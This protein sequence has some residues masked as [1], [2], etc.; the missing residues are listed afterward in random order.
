MSHS[1]TTQLLTGIRVL[2]L[3][4]NLPGPFATRLL[5][6]LGAHIVKIE[7]PGGDEARALPPLFERLNRGKECVRLDLKQ[8]GER[9]RL[10]QMVAG[11]DVLVEGFRPGVMD[12]L[13]LGWE[14]LRQ[15]NPKLV[16]CSITGYGQRGPW[17]DRAGH[18]LNYMAMSGVLDVLRGRDGAPVLGNV[19]WGDVASGSMFGVAQTLAALLHVQRGGQ[20]CHL[21]ISMTHGLRQ[22]LVMAE[23]T[24]AMLAPMLGHRPGPAEDML[25]GALPCYGLYATADGR[26]LAVGALEH[27]FWRTACDGFQR[28]EWADRHWHRGLMPNSPESNALR[29]EVATLVASRPLAH[30][31]QV[32]ET[33]DA[34]VTPV[35]SLEEAQAHPLFR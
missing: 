11:A 32:F 21:D 13:D 2:D 18:D 35:L 20:G 31:A 8:A 3:T 28:P 4:R 12:D 10:L 27:K 5:A 33:V 29:D 25:N 9:E 34:C 23:S 26:W 14:R 24:G 1:T 16:M 19:Q 15:A 30:W 6:D 17:S 7:P 22:Y